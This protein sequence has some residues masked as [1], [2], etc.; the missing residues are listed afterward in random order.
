M[1]KMGMTKT[2]LTGPCVAIGFA[3]AIAMMEPASAHTFV[4]VSVG[5]APPLPRIEHVVVRP[6]YIWAPGYWRWNGAQH[7][8]AG[9]TWVGARPGRRFV[10]AAWVR[11]G[12]AW[13]FHRGYWR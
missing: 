8:W 9:G 5:I 3:L 4:G 6:G 10:P 2:G 11:V 7:A 13:R 1:K 12:P